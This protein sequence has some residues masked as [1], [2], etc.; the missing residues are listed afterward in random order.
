MSFHS[1][2]SQVPLQPPGAFTIAQAMSPSK[3]LHALAGCSVS[4]CRSRERSMV[5]HW[6]WLTRDVTQGLLS[7]S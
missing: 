6:L 3:Q 4:S 7:K 2:P 5:T 1:T